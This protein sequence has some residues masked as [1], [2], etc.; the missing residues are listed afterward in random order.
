MANQKLT[1][2]PVITIPS[3]ATVAY[4]VESSQSYQIPVD[5]LVQ[6]IISNYG[7]LTSSLSPSFMTTGN[8]NII[9]NGLNSAPSALLSSDLIDFSSSGTNFFFDID[10]GTMYDKYVNTSTFDGGGI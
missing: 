5:T 1:Q 2:L 10:G 7:F 9:L 3:T 8:A 4:G 6:F